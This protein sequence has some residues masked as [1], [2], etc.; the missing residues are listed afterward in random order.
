MQT[1]KSVPLCACWRPHHGD[2][3]RWKARGCRRWSPWWQDGRCRGRRR[4]RRRG[5]GAAP[6]CAGRSIWCSGKPESAAERQDSA[7][8]AAGCS[9]GSAPPLDPTA[10]LERAAH[11][12]KSSLGNKPSFIWSSLFSVQN[13]WL[14]GGY[15]YDSA[16]CLIFICSGSGHLQTLMTYILLKSADSHQHFNHLSLCRVSMWAHV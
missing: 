6:R 16:I 11:T 10:S 5:G 15:I 9:T 14:S 7:P 3:E 4:W 13:G 8:R 12:S 1:D 2:P